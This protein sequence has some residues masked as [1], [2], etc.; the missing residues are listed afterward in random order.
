MRQ[1]PFMLNEQDLQKNREHWHKSMAKRNELIK[2][3]ANYG[4]HLQNPH[5][6]KI[7]ILEKLV[8]G[9]NPEA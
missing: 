3:L 1:L 7:V 2:S 8:K 4:V 5:S 6:L 9:L